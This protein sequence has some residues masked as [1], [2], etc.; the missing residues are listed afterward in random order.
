MKKLLQK[1]RKRKPVTK[2]EI[3]ADLIFMATSAIVSL[4]ITFLFDIHR[5]FY[6]WPIK[7]KFIFKTPYPYLVFVPIGT[8]IGFL[9]IKLILFGLKEEDLN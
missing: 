4:M 2:E 9:I 1:I 8:I 5:S 3:I 7:F 6:D